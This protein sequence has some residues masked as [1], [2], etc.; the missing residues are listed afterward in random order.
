[1]TFPRVPRSPTLERLAAAAGGL[2][3]AVMLLAVLTDSRPRLA[4]TNTRVLASGVALTVAPGLERCQDGEFV[5]HEASRI[6]L[7]VSTP[8]GRAGPPLDIAIRDP[9]GRLATSARVPAGYRP[10]FLDATIPRPRQDVAPGS[11]CLRNVGTTPVTFAGN[12]TGINP[13]AFNPD[14][15]KPASGEGIRV[16]YFRPGRESWLELAPEI[17]HRFATFKPSFFGSWTMWAV[18]AA[19]LLLYGAAVE[20]QCRSSR[21]GPVPT[22]SPQPAGSPGG[23]KSASWRARRRAL[24]WLPMTGWACAAIAAA[25]AALWAGVTPAFQVPDELFH[26]GYAQFLAETGRPPSLRV[27]EQPLY[28]Y[29]M[30]DEYMAVIRSLPFTV[31]GKPSWSSRQERDLRLQLDRSRLSRR[32]EMGGGGATRYS[33]L[34]YALEA[35]PVRAGAGLD[36]V[37]RLYL[38]RLIPPLLAALTV[39]FAFLFL[40]ELLPGTPWAWTLGALAVALQPV[41]GFMSG[42]VNNDNLLWPAAAA[43]IYLLSRA[44]R[45]GL[46]PR[47]GLAMGAVSVVGF[48]A[49]PSMLSLL[50]GAALGLLLMVWRAQP[51]HRR[52][53]VLGALAAAVAFVVP[54]VAWL[55]V[56]VAVLD[57][58]IGATTG[59]LSTRS[60]RI[61]PSLRGQLSHLWQFFLPRLPFMDDAFRGYPE[62]PVWETYIQGF[63]GRFGWFQYGFPLW[64]NK[65][66]LGVLL[67]I[68][69]A[70][71]AGLV[72][73][74]RVVRDRWAELACY[75]TMAISV[76]L[77]N[78]IAGYRS[79]LAA[80]VGFEQPRYLFPVLALYGAL[81]AVAA[82]AAGR[83]WGPAVGA[84]L[85]VLAAGHSLFAILVTIGR[86]YA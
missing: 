4:A 13:A 72:R 80:G 35:I 70:A 48:L 31:E 37:D 65:L 5:P 1:M 73:A 12:F 84:F 8:D 78:G 18:L 66:G 76:F 50:P 36:A 60:L 24:T 20:L 53:A 10:G 83:R 86:Y 52:R 49:K 39:A 38:M 34:Y 67:A 41:F 21:R 17:A 74:G 23:A 79:L 58:P 44:F 27:V 77:L 64:A 25:N 30:S 75:A 11:F 59:A 19:L 56:E 68:A 47:L 26:V 16:D 45:R 51:D 42:G 46:D 29:Q 69:A 85:V 63:I 54:T 9:A 71:V 32:Q 33:P 82:R 81:V 55:G 40:R 28:R 15:V 2:I 14:E 6:R 62:Y 43:L 3:I 57:R 7:Y 61:E 22:A